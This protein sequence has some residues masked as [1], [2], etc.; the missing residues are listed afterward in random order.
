MR[1]VRCYCKKIAPGEVVITDAEA[2]HLIHVL[3]A[4]TGDRVELFDGKGTVAQAI[5]EQAGCGEVRL[6]VA[7]I[8]THQPR[9][10]ARI[11]LAVSVARG[12]RFDQ[13]ITQ[14]TEL[15]IDHIAAVLFERTVKQAA[16]GASDRWTKLAISAAKQCG[17]LFLPQ[18][19]GPADLPYLLKQLRAEYSHGQIV[20]GG[21]SKEAVAIVDRD[22]DRD[23]DSADTIVF[24]GPEGGLTESENK[25]L[26][27]AGGIECKLT[28]TI[29]RIE[30]AALA[31]GTILCLQRDS[32]PG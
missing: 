16:G 5:V 22:R 7:D 30:T 19:T 15:G 14:S 25:L 26:I 29:L 3:R 31:F 1:N 18:I 20:F 27:Q 12:A 8:Q 2:H 24:I 9:T 10:K 11:I 13:I 6:S 21:F 4:Q 32:L 28:Q 17:R 23:R